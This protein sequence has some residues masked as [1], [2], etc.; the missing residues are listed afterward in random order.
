L[1]AAIAAASSV[2]EERLGS[3]VAGIRVGLVSG[4]E[5]RIRRRAPALHRLKQPPGRL[6]VRKRTGVG[7][8]RLHLQGISRRRYPDRPA[9]TAGFFC[10]YRAY[11]RVRSLRGTPRINGTATSEGWKRFGTMVYVLYLFR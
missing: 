8:F 2:A 4:G 7:A 6:R 1:R 5:T 3:A 11:T 9:A 10:C